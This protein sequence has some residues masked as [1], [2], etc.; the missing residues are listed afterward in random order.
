MY[1]RIHILTHNHSNTTQ[2]YRKLIINVFV[3]FQKLPILR[4]IIFE[5]MS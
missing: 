2:S 3:L 1:V 5:I 4:L